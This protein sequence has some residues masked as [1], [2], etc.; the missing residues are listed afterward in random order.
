MV[1]ELEEIK[2]VIE[3]DRFIEADNPF[4]EKSKD[5][6]CKN[7]FVFKKRMIY[8]VICEHGGGGESISRLLT[9]ETSLKQEKIYIDNAEAKASDI[10]KLGWY[11]G[12]TLY[13]RG[14]IKRELSSSQAL[15]CAIKE[16][17]RYNNIVDIVKEFHLTPSKLSYGLSRNCEWE[18]WRTSMAIGYANNKMIYCFPWM[19][20]LCFY[21]CMY[22]SSVFRFFKKL[23]GEG[24]IIILPTS[25]K[26]N[27][28]GLADS[29]IQIHSPRFERSISESPYFKEHFR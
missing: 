15:A 11:V 17:H 26:E 18:M 12:K 13:S 28:S 5:Y 23:T 29:V 19:D 4:G 14:L 8:G 21:D 3:S 27:V 7:T 2:L 1:A 16:H 24:A 6:I 22:N 25:R 9:N 20:S 10:E